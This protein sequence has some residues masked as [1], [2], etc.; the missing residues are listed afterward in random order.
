[1]INMR[2]KS[3]YVILIVSVF[4]FAFVVF[5]LFGVKYVKK[6]KMITTIIVG[7]DTVWTLNKKNWMNITKTTTKKDISWNNYKVFLDNKEFGT[8][9]LWYDNNKWYAFDSKK[10]AVP[11]DGELLAYQANYKID[12]IDFEE[13]EITDRS[14]VDQVLEDND[15]SPSSKT[16]SEYMTSIDFDNDGVEEDFYVITNVFAMDFVPETNFAIIFMVKDETIYYIYKDVNTND[17]SLTNGCMP[18]LVSF[19]DTDDDGIYEFVVGCGKYSISGTIKMLYQ[20]EDNKF[21][22]V[23]SNQ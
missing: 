12:V 16:T 10:N 23:I 3:T 9:S 1:M 20:F 18:Y 7:D 11:M 17:E 15:I 21:K 14:Y 5:L 13:R 6:G 2:K 8:Y 22:I 4:A 19:L